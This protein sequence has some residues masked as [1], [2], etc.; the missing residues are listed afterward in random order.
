MVSLEEQMSKTC[1]LVR[2]PTRDDRE[3]E[4]AQLVDEDGR[5]VALVEEIPASYRN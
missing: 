2:R 1:R 5:V 4:R 3:D